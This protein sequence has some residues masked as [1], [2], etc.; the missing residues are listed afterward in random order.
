MKAW[1]P[2]PAAWAWAPLA[3]ALILC[4]GQ[5]AFRSLVVDKGGVPPSLSWL[6]VQWN[7]GL[8]GGQTVQNLL[9]KGLSRKI[10]STKDLAASWDVNELS[11]ALRQLSM[12]SIF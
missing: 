8:T 12:T 5:N 2:V 6:E 9:N 3:L 1:R 4:L 11:C 7:D 10:F